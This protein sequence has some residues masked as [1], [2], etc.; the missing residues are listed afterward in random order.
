MIRILIAD[1]HPIVRQGLRELLALEGDIE[2]IGEVADA[3][4]LVAAVEQQEPDLVLL[5]IRTPGMDWA[6][7]LRRLQ[8]LNKKSRILLLTEANDRNDLVE[9]M[10]LGCSGVLLKE[11][12]TELIIRAIRKVHAGEIWLDSATTRAV[13]Y[14]FTSRPK[15]RSD[16]HNESPLSRRER[17]VVGLVA[18]G[19]KNR[20]IAE[21]LFISEITVKNH[22]HNVFDKLGISD[23]IELAL[24]VIRTG[25]YS[26]PGT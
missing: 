16:A 3:D 2:V 24:Y 15:A 5:E 19:Y 12:A 25:L 14:Q 13:M 21:T 23:R 18:Q 20:E 6:A 26:P 7:A 17:E 4:C 1:G 10:R 9:A 22:L 11:M 8:G